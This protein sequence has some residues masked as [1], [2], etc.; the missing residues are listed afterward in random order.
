MA[1]LNVS[2][3]DFE[4]IKQSLKTFLQGQSEFSDYDFEGSGLN[5]LLD[6]LAYN[7]HYNAMLTHLLANENFLDSAIKR[8]SV[9]SIAKSLGYT[10]RSA[11]G[12]TA[13]IDFSVIP[14]AAYTSNLM[15]LSR[16]VPFTTSLDNT[17]YIFYPRETVVVAKETRTAGTGFYFD[18]LKITEG[19]RISNSFLIDINN[20]SGPLTIPNINVD[21]TTIRVRVQTSGTNF[22]LN[23]YTEYSNFTEVSSSTKAYFLEEDLDGLYL[24]RFGDNI[25]GKKLDVGNVVIVDYITTNGNVT[26]TAK[27]FSCASV[28]TGASENRLIT[29]GAQASGGQSK[30]SIDSIRQTAPRFNQTRNRAVTSTDYQSLILNSNSNINSCAVWGGETNDPPIYGKVFISLTPQAGQIITQNDKDTIRTDIISPKAPVGIL[31]EFVD[32]TYVYIQLIV[33]IIYDPKTT[34]LTSGQIQSGIQGAT[35]TYFSTE[36]NVLNKNFYV[37]KL[38]KYIKDTSPSIISV[39]INPKLQVRHSMGS[40]GLGESV[41]LNFNSHVEPRTLHSTWFNSVITSGDFQVKMVDVPNSGVNPPEYTGSG[42]IYLND[43]NDNRLSKVGTIDYDT[44]IV[45]LLNLTVSSY[46]GS[47]T[48]IRINMKPHDDDKDIKTQTLVRVSDP[49]TSAVEAK[50][51]KNTVLRVDDTVLNPVTGARKGLDILVSQYVEDE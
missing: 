5:V 34:A 32:P 33:G 41:T 8:S 6:T 27:S 15:T 42:V 49:I 12:S 36:L 26:D 31:A 51:S 23:T 22:G 43:N 13:T 21:T 4:Q 20:Q 2:E 16:D 39:N 50:P 19:T 17:S 28:L 30:E 10:P 1:Q 45:T 38:H 11:R 7:T 46:L 14:D 3:L 25:I 35:D 18:D 9:V 44:G 24:L 37:S 48:F 29:L 40:L 47:D